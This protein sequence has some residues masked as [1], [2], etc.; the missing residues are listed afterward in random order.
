MP[1]ESKMKEALVKNKNEMKFLKNIKVKTDY[2]GNTEALLTSLLSKWSSTV[3]EIADDVSYS[4]DM[5]LSQ[6]S[7]LEEIAY[8]I[9]RVRDHITG[10][11]D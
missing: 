8:E 9:S 7:K 5:T 3:S 1:R 6:L 11:A 10:D 4:K 2:S